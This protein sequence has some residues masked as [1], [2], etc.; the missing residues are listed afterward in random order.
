MESDGER[1]VS[2]ITRKLLPHH[3]FTARDT[4]VGRLVS[5]ATGGVRQNLASD[6][7]FTLD[8]M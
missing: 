4:E 7:S 5:K 8:F 1:R 2:D 3:H 6:R